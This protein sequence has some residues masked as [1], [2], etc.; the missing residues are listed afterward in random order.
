MKHLGGAALVFERRPAGQLFA[1]PVAVAPPASP[2]DVAFGR[3]G[4]VGGGL[5]VGTWSLVQESLEEEGERPAVVS[6]PF[7]LAPAVLD[8]NHGSG[9]ETKIAR[10]IPS[11]AL[12][13]PG[14]FG[15][16]AL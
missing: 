14:E 5:W 10:R 1:F 6:S 9:G 12:A 4:T 7:G 8:A 16:L 3:L 11:V 13:F 2:A 15:I